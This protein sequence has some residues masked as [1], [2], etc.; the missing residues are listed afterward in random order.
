M[1]QGADGLT[2]QDLLDLQTSKWANRSGHHDA[3]DMLEVFGSH[4]RL[5]P[6]LQSAHNLAGGTDIMSAA[7]TGHCVHP[8]F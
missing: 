1:W 8:P 6:Y 5:E 3:C 7:D 4:E 2:W